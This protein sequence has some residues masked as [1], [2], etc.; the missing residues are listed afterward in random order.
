MLW[1]WVAGLEE[2]FA[3]GALRLRN[4]PS[5]LKAFL[6]HASSAALLQRREAP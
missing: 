6:P 5:E 4:V 3:L 1:L 2:R